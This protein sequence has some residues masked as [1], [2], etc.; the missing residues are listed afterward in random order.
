L[1]L[2]ENGAITLGKPQCDASLSILWF[3][4][5]LG[6][7]PVCR[8]VC[9]FTAPLPSPAYDGAKQIVPLG[10]VGDG[11]MCVNDCPGPHSN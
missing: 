11:Q 2:V 10:D 9:L 5:D 8:M 3:S 1:K 7:E 6:Y 4:A